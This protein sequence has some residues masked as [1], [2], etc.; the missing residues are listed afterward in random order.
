MRS[1]VEAAREELREARA[2]AVLTGAGISAESGIPTFRGA[3][4]YRKSLR[5]EDLASPQGFAANPVLVWTWYEERRRQIAKAKPNA[6][7]EA[8]VELEHRKPSFTLITQNVHGLHELA[9]SRK[10]LRLH[11]NIWSIRCES[12]GAER[13]DRSELDVLPPVC[14]QCGGRERPGVVW[15]GESL[16]ANV[17]SRASRAVMECDVLLVVGTAAQVYPAAGMIDIALC[18]GQPAKS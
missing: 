8:L 1:N 4:G 2:V 14:A 13:I 7:H 15:F 17:L 3:G 12:C 9:G 11:G 10:V 5:F 18:G 16:P 6:G